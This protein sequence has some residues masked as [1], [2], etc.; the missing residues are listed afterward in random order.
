MIKTILIFI[1]SSG[2]LF[3]ATAEFYKKKYDFYLKKSEKAYE[4]WQLKESIC[5]ISRNS[6]D[7]MHRL[8]MQIYGFLDESA[9]AIAAKEEEQANKVSLAIEEKEAKELQNKYIEYIDKI[10]ELSFTVEEDLKKLPEWFIV[11]AAKKSNF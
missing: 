1:I 10:T 11:P 3:G 5:E 9:E 7:E 8:N 2:L 4:D 6:N